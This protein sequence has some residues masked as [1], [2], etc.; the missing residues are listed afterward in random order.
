[1]FYVPHGRGSL[2]KQDAFNFSHNKNFKQVQQS[3]EGTRSLRHRGF[4][5]QVS[6]ECEN[7]TQC[8]PFKVL[9]ILTMSL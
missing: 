8:S 1:M 4:P 6:M 5:H 2:E 3:T 9:P 7:Y